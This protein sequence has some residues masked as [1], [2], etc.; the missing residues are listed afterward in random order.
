MGEGI[1]SGTIVAV[2]VKEGDR[3]EV[4]QSVLELE[5]DKA[6]V[7][8]PSTVAGVVTKVHVK[9]NTEAKIGQIVLTV[10]DAADGAAAPAPAA[11]EKAP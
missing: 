2:L 3:I 6:V 10:D 4:D 7:E 1:E 9:P 8:M 5:T 11:T